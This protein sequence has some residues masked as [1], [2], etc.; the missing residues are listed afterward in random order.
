MI[1]RRDKDKY[2][3]IALWIF[4]CNN[5]VDEIMW[6]LKKCFNKVEKLEEVYVDVLKHI[7][8]DNEC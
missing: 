2:K 1:K 8:E 6:L 3:S 7:G 5:P 4:Q